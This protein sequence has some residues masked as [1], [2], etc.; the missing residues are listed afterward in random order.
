MARDFA[1]S[2]LR[3]RIRT[4]RAIHLATLDAEE[5]RECELAIDRYSVLLACLDK[6]ASDPAAR[7]L[8]LRG[9][10]TEDKILASAFP[11]LFQRS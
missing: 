7:G 2:Q 11:R 6:E 3:E 10:G 5:A 9:Y 8:P 1:A 4:L